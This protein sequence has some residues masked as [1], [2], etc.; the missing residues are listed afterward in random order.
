M[1]AWWVALA[2]AH[3]PD[4]CPPSPLLEQQAAAGSLTAAGEKC[5]D[6]LVSVDLAAWIRWRQQWAVK[7]SQKI[8]NQGREAALRIDD[9]ERWLLTA[10][11]IG[12][13]Q[14]EI[15]RELLDA[16]LPRASDWTGIVKYTDNLARWYKLQS[17]LAPGPATIIYAQGLAAAGVTDARLTNGRKECAAFASL[18][19]C[20]TSVAWTAPLA[21]PP[22]PEDLDRCSD[23]GRLWGGAVFGSTYAT[24]RDCVLRMVE[25]LPEGPDR[26]DAGRLVAAMALAHREKGEATIVLRRLSALI[27]PDRGI[28]ERAAELHRAAGDSAGVSWWMVWAQPSTP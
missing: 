16:T 4:E 6:K 22:L 2:W 25:T 1:V 14:P 28:A 17:E 5:L 24:E 21:P 7:P 12:G 26:Q 9:P 3:G 20:E 15:A 10:E 19:V 23:L 8:A 27:A 18:E 11:V 13:S